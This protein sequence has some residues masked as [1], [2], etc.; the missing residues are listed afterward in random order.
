MRR[1]VP[2]TSLMF[3]LLLL[4]SCVFDG[5]DSSRS[6][7]ENE[8]QPIFSIENGA[9]RTP[10]TIVALH[11]SLPKQSTP[12]TQ[13]SIS[14]GPECSSSEWE[15]FQLVRPDWNSGIENGIA[16]ISV[17]FKNVAGEENPC[18]HDDIIIDKE[19]PFFLGFDIMAPGS[20]FSSSR[21]LNIINIGSLDN[22]VSSMLI[23]NNGLCLGGEWLPYQEALMN[24]DS[25]IE[26]GVASLS[27][28]LRDSVGNEST[29]YS[30]T[31]TVDETKPEI[32]SLRINNGSGYS[33][34]G[35]LTLNLHGSDSFLEEMYFTEEAGCKEG[36]IWEP[37]NE[38]KTIYIAEAQKNLVIYAKLRDAAKNESPCI[39]GYVIIDTIPP[40]GNV[41]INGQPM[42][43]STTLSLS[44]NAA[45]DHLT[46]MYIT[47]Q[48]DCASQG[49]WETFKETKDYVWKGTRGEARVYSKYKDAAGNI[50]ACTGAS[51]QVDTSAP[52]A[53]KN[54]TPLL[55]TIVQT[56]DYTSEWTSELSPLFS[57]YR[58]KICGDSYCQS[59]CQTEMTT[60]ENHYPLNSLLPSKEYY[61]CVRS[62]FSDGRFSPYAHSSGHLSFPQTYS[63]SG[64]VMGL[65]AGESIDLSD[66]EG[67]EIT[68]SGDGN[69]SFTMLP[70]HS[71]KGS[72]YLINIKSIQAPQKKC[73]T[74][75]NN[76]GY[77]T[78]DITNV[79]ISCTPSNDLCE[80]KVP[81]SNLWGII[82]DSYS[83]KC[84]ENKLFIGGNFSHV[85][86]PT[87]PGVALH[88]KSGF[89]P[90]QFDKI[91][92]G[93]VNAAVSDGKG[94]WYIGGTFTKVAGY[95]R[96]Y[97]AHILP[98]NTIDL[99][100]NIPSNGII[101]S[102]WLDNKTL[103]VAGS[104]SRLGN[105]ARNKL[106][107]INLEN[108]Q[109]KFY[110]S[111][112]GT[113]V[114][115]LY[116]KDKYLYFGGDF[117][118][119]GGVTRNRIAAINTTNN[120][121]V[122]NFNPD[123]SG[124]V[125]AIVAQ[126][127][128][129]YIGG[130]FT[131]LGGQTRNYLG[132]V[133]TLFGQLKNFDPQLNAK[134]YG[135]AS[136]SEKLYVA[137]DFTTAFAGNANRKFFAAFKIA[138]GDIDELNLSLN[139]PVRTLA[140]KGR[141]L[142]LGGSFTTVLGQNRPRLASINLDEKILT[143]WNP[144]ASGTVFTLA[145]A[146]EQIYAGGIF[147]MV[148]GKEIS[149]LSAINLQSGSPLGWSPNPDSSIFSQY[150][151]P[152][153]KKLY[154]GGRFTKYQNENHAGLVAI[155]LEDLTLQNWSPQVTTS[156][157]GGGIK[158]IEQINDQLLIGGAFSSVNGHSR[159]S[160]ASFDL[161][162]NGALTN[163]APITSNSDVRVIYKIG[164][165]IWLGGSF[166]QIDG[167]TRNNMAIFDYEDSQKTFTL[168]PLAPEPNNYVM[169]ILQANN[170]IY[171]G[172]NFTEIMSNPRERLASFS[173]EGNLNSWAPK[174]N[175]IVRSMASDG[176]QLLIGGDFTLL[177]ASTRPF[178]GAVDLNEG[179]T[180][181]FN[182]MPN[183]KVWSLTSQGQRLFMG[184]NFSSYNNFYNNIL[185]Q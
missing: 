119:I 156:F 1:L 167:Q 81:Q 122:N 55:N 72:R 157:S 126:G 50:S 77:I 2:I 145:L 159:Y 134:V 108:G 102:L 48:A 177:N 103:W 82:G 115:T 29:C 140:L 172:G 183:G 129:L 184:G 173:L 144:G 165:Q 38:N 120:I 84:F 93:Q 79:I 21:Y 59:D 35:T 76:S 182:P 78:S 124:T 83:L 160:L 33:N 20:L 158:S 17:K 174:A 168:N 104:F 118:K 112:D 96:A 43:S 166:F 128:T 185:A 161:S 143:P 74:L 176:Q 154:I 111:I 24:W 130:D 127:D 10:N 13:V 57:N 9:E 66:A 139:F 181:I 98:N 40:Q 30:Q 138:N 180:K 41:T 109:T 18:I 113:A 175:N 42:T 146:D 141:E 114:N 147:T 62:E 63:V 121:L 47:S 15:N 94:G 52:Q 7:T 150:I 91:T 132:A 12:A 90:N 148:G 31:I 39:A 32:F 69:G 5:G 164:N 11:F 87:G 179:T 67:N 169:T 97:L 64:Q 3:M 56:G 151:N 60:T 19:G 46:E 61:I 8:I 16:T 53:P 26:S 99:N 170:Q 116:K 178:A 142:F 95:Y 133:N 100:F 89:A 4:C 106:S 49:I 131:S 22:D 34:T 155:N 71:V 28:R 171:I 45:D 37:Y 86:P 153:T 149:N 85:S 125:R 163:W 73:T 36:G 137:G 14:N 27:M 23:S 80:L 68:V 123:A 75:T 135:L 117:Q 152:D 25:E 6:Q 44:L 107:S 105:F 88:L 51:I 65:D 92:N 110:Y 136:D 70:N 162:Q 58:V 54:V 101:N